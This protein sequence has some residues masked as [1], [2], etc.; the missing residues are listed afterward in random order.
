VDAGG[1][2]GT[3]LGTSLKE[4][5][6]LGIDAVSFSGSGS[7]INVALGDGA[8][9][10]NHLG[11][12]LFNNNLN[13]TLDVTQSQLGEIAGLNASNLTSAGIDGIRLDL[14]VGNNVDSQGV[15]NL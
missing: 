11:S 9:L 2:A 1:N 10:G 14:D 6:K 15:R 7:D 3:H 13:V 12:G 4:L 8:A 5:Q